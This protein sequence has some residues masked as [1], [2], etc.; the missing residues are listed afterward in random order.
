MG[1]LE[2]VVTII[3]PRPGEDTVGLDAYLKTA[4][5]KLEHFKFKD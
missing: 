2:K 5:K 1:F 4:E 3:K